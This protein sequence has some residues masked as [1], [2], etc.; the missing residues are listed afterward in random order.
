MSLKDKHIPQ[1]TCIACRQIKEKKSLIRLVLTKEGV[2][3][4]DPSTKKPGRGVYLCPGRSCW[5]LGLK[6]NQL[7]HALRTKLTPDN[8]QALMDYGNKL[9]EKG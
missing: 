3:E 6:G 5:E 4:V 7:E 2:I 1:R 8:R 9:L